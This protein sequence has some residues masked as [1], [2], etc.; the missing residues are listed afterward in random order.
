MCIRDRCGAI[1]PKN[2]R[3]RETCTSVFKFEFYS[4]IFLLH[5]SDHLPIRKSCSKNTSRTTNI[6]SP[7]FGPYSRPFLPMRS[8]NMRDALCHGHG[9]NNMGSNLIMMMFSNI[10]QIFANLTIPCALACHNLSMSS[11]RTWHLTLVEIEQPTQH[12]ALFVS[13]TRPPPYLF[14]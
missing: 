7:N 14:T 3:L 9:C 5:R 10:S 6:R 1:F 11:W 8:G 2:R 13:Y 12:S 4:Q